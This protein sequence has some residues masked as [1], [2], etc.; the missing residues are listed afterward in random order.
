MNEMVERILELKKEKDVVILAHYYVTGDIQDIAD[1]V[2]DSY[3]LSKK[4]AEA[5]EKVILFCGVEF[6]G[7][8]AK[9]L[10]PDKT[11]LMPDMEAD[12]PMAHMVTPEDI[13]QLKKECP[14]AAVVCYINSTAETKAC[15]DV[16]VTSSNAERVVA[17]M[18][19]KEIYFVPDS[20]LGR[21]IAE[22][23]PEK[24][25]YFH[26]G[27]CPTH[28]RISEA[29][30]RRA[31]ED[32]PGAKVLMHPECIPEALALADY[33]GSTSGIIDFPG[34]DGGDSYIIATEEGVMHQMKKQ[35]PDK[36]FYMVDD[37]CICE[38]M[39]KNTLEKILRTLETFD[40]TMEMDEKLR[41]QASCSLKKMHELAQ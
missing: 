31:K 34:K 28:A 37:L 7:E 13:R 35:Y 4:A 19:Q 10:S 39:K 6:M 23:L 12:C 24:T 32:H 40:N 16:C 38:N 30:V 25:F 18:P 11:V 36:A 20:N 41:V 3:L 15:A 1:Y 27:F 2:G 14:D 33:I 5:S 9:I 26:N 17:A 21:H 8:S 29:L 22:K